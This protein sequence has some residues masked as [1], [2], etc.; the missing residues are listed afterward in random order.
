MCASRPPSAAAG[1]CDELGD[2]LARAADGDAGVYDRIFALISGPVAGLSLRVVRNQALA[3]EVAQQVLLEV[4][5]TASRYDPE[6][7]SGTAWVMTLAH[8]RAVD[9]VRSEQ[10]R[11]D[12]EE[13]PAAHQSAPSDGPV[14]AVESRLEWERIQDYLG[15]LSQA[16]REAIC[17]AYFDGYTYAEVAQLLGVSLGTVKT[18]IRDGMEYV[19][20]EFTRSDDPTAG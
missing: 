1:P 11:A 6:R 16:Q 4:W 18:T 17:L 5:E 10:S 19:R 12:G 14:A 3:E 2:L 7:G 20:D 8:L 9:R 13:V 15:S